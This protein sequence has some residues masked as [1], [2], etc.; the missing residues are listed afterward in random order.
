MIV[1]IYD[2]NNYWRTQIEKDFTSLAPRRMLQDMAQDSGSLHIWTWDGR[3]SRD[4]RQAIWPDYKTKR[5]AASIDIYA[6]LELFRELLQSSTAYQITL[7]G[8]EA[9]DVIAALVEH[10]YP[11]A[12]Q[13]Q[14]FSNDLDLMALAAH[15]PKVIGGWRAKEG[16]SAEQIHTY[17]VFCGDPSDCIP[18]VKG[19]GAKAWEAADKKVLRSISLA[20]VRDQ[21]VDELIKHMF[22]GESRG[23]ESIKAWVLANTETIAK[24]HM[25]VD[26]LP[27]PRGA[28]V[29]NMLR[30]IPDPAKIEAKLQE[31]LL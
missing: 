18:G 4:A 11:S 31:F 19:F 13:I 9:D 23:Q 10:Y 6:S 3:G 17:K 22:L 14:V 16:V 20:C 2:G 28:L 12:S 30:P 29:D 26:F 8:F 15:R 24:M 1:K 21:P 7:P 27:V 25:V 5:H